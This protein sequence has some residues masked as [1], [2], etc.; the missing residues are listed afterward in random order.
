MFG[1]QSPDGFRVLIGGTVDRLR[2]RDATDPS[3]WQCAPFPRQ[4]TS[5]V[6]F[7]SFFAARTWPA[8]YFFEIY[9]PVSA[10]LSSRI[11]AK[12]I[13]ANRR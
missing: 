11:P 6:L 3:P 1:R 8:R 5:L 7:S 10:Y 4:T 13:A 12:I 2:R 9:F